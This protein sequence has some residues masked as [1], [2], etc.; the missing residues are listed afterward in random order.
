MAVL[1]KA[2]TAQLEAVC[3]GLRPLP[4]YDWLRKPESGLVMVR[5]RVGGTGAKFNVGEMTVTR[6]ALRTAAG[7]TG[8]AYVRGRDPRHAE[9]A[10]LID[11]LMQDS[12]RRAVVESAVIGP[13]ERVQ[14][15]RR[16]LAAGKAAATRVEFYTVARE[17]S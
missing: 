10:A 3:D 11:A 12:T 2:A 15:A 1:A 4:A 17:A 5:S 13:L 6:C 16:A 8:I 9:L 14:N 7:L